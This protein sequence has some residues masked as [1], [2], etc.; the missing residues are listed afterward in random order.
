MKVRYTVSMAGTRFTINVGDVSEVPDVAA[1][2]LIDAGFAVQVPDDTVANFKH[3]VDCPEASNGGV[4][5]TVAAV[6]DEVEFD[7]DKPAQPVAKP[8]KK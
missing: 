8:K 1:K 6:G 3:V 4:A 7:V 5:V 2:R